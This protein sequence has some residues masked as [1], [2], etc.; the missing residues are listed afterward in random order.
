MFGFTPPWI[1]K[2]IVGISIVLFTFL[3][4]GF[5]CD[6]VLEGSR[7]SSFAF[8]GPDIVYLKTAGVLSLYF[9]PAAIFLVL[10]WRHREKP[11][12]W[13]A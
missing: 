8:C 5:I 7:T 10:Y 6:L 13:R 12:K 4:A 11:S 3:P 9:L 2:Y 1:L